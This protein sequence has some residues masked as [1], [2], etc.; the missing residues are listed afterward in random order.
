MVQTA[1]PEPGM[2]L[3]PDQQQAYQEEQQA[4]IHARQIDIKLRATQCENELVGEWVALD[5]QLTE[6]HRHK[7]MLGMERAATIDFT[8]A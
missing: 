6:L 1:A 4:W 5:A 2:E 7:A 3:L 8:K